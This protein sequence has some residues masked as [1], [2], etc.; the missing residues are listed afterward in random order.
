MRAARFVSTLVLTA[1]GSR[2]P[3]SPATTQAVAEQLRSLRPGLGVR[4]A[5]CERTAPP[6]R[7]ML[8]S[9]SGDAVVSP[10]LLAD[11]YHARVDIP[12]VIAA[13]GL[14]MLQA[15]VLGEDPRLLRVLRQR[16]A[17]VGVSR[18]DG[19]LGVAVVAVGS[20]HASANEQTSTVAAALADGT[21]WAGVAT[22]FATGPHPTVAEAVDGL[23]SGRAARVVIAPW[24]LA[25]G[26]ITDR[27]AAYAEDAGIPIAQPLGAHPLVAAT[28]LDRFDQAIV[29]HAAA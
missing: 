28:V 2:D 17:E 6:L 7:E 27:V 1:H 9:V 4:V 10:L 15:E 14:P 24:F 11:A 23:R 13:S 12:A 5:F 21:C 29:G 19:D 20:S 3:R 25:P 18:L 8:S 26:R 22:A 16:L